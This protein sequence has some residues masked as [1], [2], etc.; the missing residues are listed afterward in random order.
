MMLKCANEIEIQ[1]KVEKRFYSIKMLSLKIKKES[2]L[3]P[4][5]NEKI[6]YKVLMFAV[7]L[8]PFVA[9]I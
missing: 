5:C 7:P 4:D 9:P 2:L 3:S 1:S 8:A 6:K